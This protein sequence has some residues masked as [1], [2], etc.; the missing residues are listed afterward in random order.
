MRRSSLST[1]LYRHI[2]LLMMMAGFC[3]GLM[4][5]IVANR[6]I[7]RASDAQL[8]NASRLLYTL[9]QDELSAM[10]RGKGFPENGEALLSLEERQAFQASYDWC[11]FAVLWDGRVIA[12]SG[13]GAPTDLVPKKPGLHD[14]SASGDQWRSYGLEGYDPRLLVIVA[15]RGAMQE[16][17]VV[18][19]MRKLA[20]PFFGLIGVSAFLLWLT[21]RAGL[22]EIKRLSRTLEDRSLADLSPLDPQLWPSDFRTLII[23]LNRLFGRLG[24]GYEKEQSFTDDVAHELRTP[25]AALRAQAQLLSRAAPAQL[26]EDADRLT[27]IIDRTNDLVDGMLVLAR[28]EATSA[29]A[30]PVDV[31]ELVADIVAEALLRLPPDT[32]EFQVTPEYRVPWRCDPA[33]LKIAVSAVVDNAVLHAAEG[34]VVEIDLQRREGRLEIRIM[35]RGKGIEA[36]DRDRVLKRF[37]RGNV[38]VAG[39]GLGLSIAVRAMT[40]IGG[41]VLLE[42]RGDGP[43]LCVTLALPS[44]A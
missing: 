10:R 28:L 5:Y 17:S 43:G 35:D 22:S 31:H 34:R 11:M 24:Q 29:D 19:V 44:T 4:L 33:I 12:Q 6:E 16:F 15:E 23:A 9:M 13:W 20:L 30:C 21:L 14:F 27:A 18:P 32:I 2:L 38:A 40:L 41:E 1:R 26:R 37:E 39:S 3:M 36:E 7:R 42:N 25:I 8:V